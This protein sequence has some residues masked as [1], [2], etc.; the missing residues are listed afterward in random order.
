MINV[1]TIKVAERSAMKEAANTLGIVAPIHAIEVKS[2]KT[3]LVVGLSSGYIAPHRTTPVKGRPT[4]DP[5]GIG[6]SYIA[7]EALHHLDVFGFVVLRPP[8]R[9]VAMNDSWS[10]EDPCRL[11]M[12]CERTESLSAG[13]TSFGHI[14]C[15]VCNAQIPHIRIAAVPNTR[16]CTKCKKNQEIAQYERTLEHRR[17]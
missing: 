17:K 13:I 2:N 8:I 10:G 11:A 4:L 7:H 9:L 6:G 16:I 1:S 12:N 3:T 5:H 14:A 15:S